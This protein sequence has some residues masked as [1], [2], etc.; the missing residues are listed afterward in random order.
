M[1]LTSLLERRRSEIAASWAARMRALPGNQYREWSEQE[2]VAWAERALD[3]IIASR[4]E[5]SAAPLERHATVISRLRAEQRFEIDQVIEGLLL[6]DEVALPYIV[7]GAG[8]RPG[9]GGAGLAAARSLSASLRVLVAQFAAIFARTLR[10]QHEHLVVLEER[11]RLARDLHDSVSQALY[12]VGMYAEAAARLLDGGKPE[13]A[14]EHLREVRQSAIDA[15]R[16]MRLL[17]FDLRPLVLRE[18]GLVPALRAR[19][20]MVE[21][22]AGVEAEIVADQGDRLPGDIEDAFYGI[23]R[24]ALNNALRHARASRIE[25][26]LLRGISTASLTVKDDGSGFDVEA[27]REQGGLGLD[28]MRERAARIGAELTLESLSGK[29]TAVTVAVRGPLEGSR[30]E[31]A[32]DGQHRD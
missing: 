2:A 7:E 12:G 3:A 21:R 1:G 26:R 4:R 23:A 20:A 24:E 9:E 32:Q 29:G 8:E 15:L 31:E 27:V 28:G 18:E 19:L 16:E 14:A 22:R 5:D 10:E 17:L 11:T 13:A 25:V 6:L 30:Q